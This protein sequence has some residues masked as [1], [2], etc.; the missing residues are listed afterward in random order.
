[1]NRLRRPAALFFCLASLSAQGAERQASTSALPDAV[2]ELLRERF[3]M[4]RAIGLLQDSAS[5]E[6]LHAAL[7]GDAGEFSFLI[8]R[9]AGDVTI[10]EFLPTDP[11]ASAVQSL[12]L[13]IETATDAV[14]M[15]HVLL[16][17]ESEPEAERLADSALD[18]VD[19]GGPRS[20]RLYLLGI[21]QVE[22]RAYQVLLREEMSSTGGL[23]FWIHF[24]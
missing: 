13:T 11:S 1:M 24:R 23:M 2:H 6:E 19:Q 3:Y 15:V 4:D 22:D 7:A 5:R 21:H 16:D 9:P 12:T 10:D 14:E 8:G 20:T 17:P 18:E